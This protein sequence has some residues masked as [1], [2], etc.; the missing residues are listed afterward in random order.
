VPRKSHEEI[1]IREVEFGRDDKGILTM[2]IT[3]R[4]EMIPKETKIERI[5]VI[6]YKLKYLSER[7]GNLT[8]SDLNWTIKMEDAFKEQGNLSPRQMTVLEG[9]YGRY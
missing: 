9:I 5:E 6:K 8:P 3:E 2:T 7:A 4:K 1:T